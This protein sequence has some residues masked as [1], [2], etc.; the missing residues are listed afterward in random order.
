MVGQAGALVYD[1]RLEDFQTLHQ[2]LDALESRFV[3]EAE[4]NLAKVS[5]ERAQQGPDE[6][7][8]A[9]HGR[10]R[11]LFARAYPGATEEEPLVRRFI[12]GLQQLT[13]QQQVMR[14]N[15]RSY[16]AALAAA[17]NEEV[18]NKQ[19]KYYRL[20]APGRADPNGP[21]PMEIGALQEGRRRRCPVQSAQRKTIT[22]WRDA[23]SYGE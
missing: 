11:M 20:G 8:Q 4:A 19:A 3:P 23:L 22:L 14:A 6:T 1:L 18:V 5:F 15:P 17:Q 7:I 12:V 16:S 10:L 2:F 13:V 9:W 21:E